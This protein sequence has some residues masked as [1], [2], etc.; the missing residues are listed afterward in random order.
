KDLGSVA[1]TDDIS[2]YLP[3]SDEQKKRIPHIQELREKMQSASIKR[4]LDNE[5][6]SKLEQEILRLE[7][8]VIEIQDM[9]FLGGQD[10]VDQKCKQIVGDPEKPDSRNR[11]QEL[12]QLLIQDRAL[13]GLIEFQQNFAPYFKENV[14]RMS[15]TEPIELKDLPESVLDRYSNESRD[16][17]LVTIFPARSPWQSPEALNHFT[18]DLERV[19]KEV[20][21]LPP[22]FRAVIKIFARDGR[23]AVLLT[24][25]I[26][27]LL[28]YAD[29]KKL[30][31]ALM[32]MIPL[33][34]GVF[35]MVG[36]MHLF[37]MKLNFINVIGL[38]LIIGIGID[39]GVHIMH[40][41]RNEGSG[42]IYTVFS[43][44]G[45]AILLTTLTTMFAFG[46][47]VFSIFRGWASFGGALAIGVGACF[48]TTL[49]IL[50]GIL[51]LIERKK[52]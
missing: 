28:L 18:D 29:F 8:N 40:R 1:F 43:S 22:V 24:L 2:A 42:R 33:A 10:K 37:G 49:L 16:K 12:A 19:T 32:A 39:D 46:S 51:G 7:M 38:P 45:K 21:G 50:S 48:L 35:W 11:I 6:L 20:S 52:Q 27:F 30:R 9:A 34:C 31:H 4:G 17:F 47:L 36:L 3:N 13:Q 23:N 44:T 14:L 26:V 15:S 5:D 41:W 25:G